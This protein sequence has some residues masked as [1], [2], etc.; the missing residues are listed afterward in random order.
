MLGLFIYD[1]K[2]IERAKEYVRREMEYVG[3]F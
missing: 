1:E 2:G 3:L